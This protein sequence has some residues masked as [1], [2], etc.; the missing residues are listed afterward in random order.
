MSLQSQISNNT[1]NLLSS[2]A[3]TFYLNTF[4]NLIIPLNSARFHAKNFAQQNSDWK[5]YITP[6]MVIDDQILVSC[7]FN[8]IQAELFLSI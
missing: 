5:P 2:N 8:P 7:N 3:G 4:A 1:Y 6:N